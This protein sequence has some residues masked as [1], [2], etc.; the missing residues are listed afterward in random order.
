M[1][2]IE[3]KEIDHVAKN[4]V[5]TSKIGIQCSEC[6]T[7]IIDFFNYVESIMFFIDIRI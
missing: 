4:Y 6:T 1:V 5:Y 3:T 2:D 7:T